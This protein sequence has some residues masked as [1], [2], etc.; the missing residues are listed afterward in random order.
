MTA[1]L[2]FILHLLVMCLVTSR[3]ALADDKNIVALKFNEDDGTTVVDC[4]F[5]GI[6]VP[7]GC[8]FDLGN[9]NWQPFLPAALKPTFANTP[10]FLP[11][12]PT[13]FEGCRAKQ[14]STVK[15]GEMDAH[16]LWVYPCSPVNG[17]GNIG[18]FFL[19]GGIWK[20]DLEKGELTKIARIPNELKTE[21]LYRREGKFDLGIEASIGT[22]RFIAMIDTGSGWSIFDRAFVLKNKKYFQP[23]S[24][25]EISQRADYDVTFKRTESIMSDGVTFEAGGI[26]LVSNFSRD[27]SYRDLAKE[28]W[29]AALGMD[30]LRHHVWYFDLKKNLW[31]IE[32]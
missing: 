32:P 31:A 6:K 24:S 1:K 26:A 19:E 30:F 9:T 3:I 11:A 2:I 13:L 5:N 25:N 15:V 8:T 23:P 7:S 12:P 14:V 28:G 20:I 27:K 22:T 17:L 21:K 4:S 16:A 18:L 10:D 29:P